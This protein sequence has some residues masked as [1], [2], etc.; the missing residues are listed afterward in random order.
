MDAVFAKRDEFA[1]ALIIL[2]RG[3][4]DC[5]F[6]LQQQQLHPHP[7]EFRLVDICG[8]VSVFT[9]WM[10]TGDKIPAPGSGPCV[11]LDVVVYT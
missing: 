10:V 9:G 8:V 5:F 11:G 7:H 1:A 4:F 2:E 6:S 3:F